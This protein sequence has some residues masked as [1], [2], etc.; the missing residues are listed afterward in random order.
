MT[1]KENA[2]P[3][4]ATMERAAGTAAYSGAATSFSGEHSTL[5]GVRQ[6][7]C[8][9]DVL[10]IGAENAISARILAG[11]L[12]LKD[13]RAVSRLVERERRS[14]VPICALAGTPGGYFLP[15]SPGELERYVKALNRRVR[16]IKKTHDA[17]N[18]SLRK[19]SGQ[20]IVRGWNNG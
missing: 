1:Q 3:I 2:H 17:V 7:D 19:L 12:G 16:E 6:V 5:S 15:S 4:A 14:G 8:V 9:A 10:P 13:I 18:E 20:E 11:M